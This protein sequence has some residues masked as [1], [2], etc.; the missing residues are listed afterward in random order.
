MASAYP[1]SIH[2]VLD[3]K[4][5]PFFTD[6]IC[7][8]N[9]IGQLLTRV[10]D[11]AV[12]LL[13]IATH[14]GV[15]GAEEIFR[16]MRWRAGVGYGYVCVCIYVLGVCTLAKAYH[17]FQRDQLNEEEGCQTG[18][19]YPC[20]APD[21]LSPPTPSP[22]L[23]MNSEVAKM[24]KRDTQALT[25]SPAVALSACT[26]RTSQ[27]LKSYFMLHSP[28]E[29]LAHSPIYTEGS[30]SNVWAILPLR[31]GRTVAC[32]RHIQA[33]LALRRLPHLFDIGLE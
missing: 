24:R 26:L 27:I 15:P 21:L 25:L 30:C 11:W 20:I 9:R 14:I 19:Q 29:D 10:Y 32:R 8:T 2:G 6:W 17:T 18:K 23:S 28:H 5:S 22:A 12:L 33:S 31:V 16:D 13:G 3:N 4:C 7:R 1:F